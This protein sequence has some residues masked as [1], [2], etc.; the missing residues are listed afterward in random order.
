M[1]ID[2]KENNI[3]ITKNNKYKMKDPMNKFKKVISHNIKAK[4]FINEILEHWIKH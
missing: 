2:W 1:E 4:V 3:F